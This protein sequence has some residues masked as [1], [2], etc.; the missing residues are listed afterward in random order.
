MS[1]IKTVVTSLVGDSKPM[2]N[3]RSTYYF[4]YPRDKTGKRTG[5]TI[6]VLVDNGRIFHGISTCS[7]EDTFCKAT[8]RSL[9][10]ERAQ[11]ALD[12]HILRGLK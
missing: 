7:T 2:S 9:A 12:K 1:M 6:A 4:I 8:G 5:Q 10:L 3:S 11:E